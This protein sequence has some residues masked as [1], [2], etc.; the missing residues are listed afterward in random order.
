MKTNANR[1][2]S[3]LIL[4]H[5]PNNKLL[6]NWK[7]EN[8]LYRMSNVSNDIYLVAF[9]NHIIVRIFCVLVK[10]VSK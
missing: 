2:L 7:M 3:M 8:I 4:L 10:S 9:N 5:V 1:P 6:G